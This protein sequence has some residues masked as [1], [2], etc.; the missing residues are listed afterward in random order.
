MTLYVWALTQSRFCIRVINH[1]A[2]LWHRTDM[3]SNVECFHA[4]RSTGVATVRCSLCRK[5][6]IY[7]SHT[8][9]ALNILHSILPWTLKLFFKAHAQLFFGFQRTCQIFHLDEL[10]CRI[11]KVVRNRPINFNN[12]H[13]SLGIMFWNWL[14]IFALCAPHNTA[15]ININ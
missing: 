6:F 11:K 1:T 13:F 5:F 12:R 9:T 4:W 10:I 15:V 7:C 8:K 3:A 14:H 2:W